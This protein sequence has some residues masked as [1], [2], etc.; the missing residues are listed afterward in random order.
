MAFQ[1]IQRQFLAHL[2]NPEYEPLP[3]GFAEQGAAI[4][5]D[6]LYNKFNDSLELC[7]PVTHNVL[8]EA[9]WQQLL[10]AFIAEHRCKSPYY[11]QIPDEFIRYL[12]TERVS[13]YDPPYLLELAHFEW[14]EMVLA[15]AEAEPVT[16]STLNAVNDW[17]ACRPLFV[18][19]FEVLH[20]FY[21]VQRINAS[22]Q[23]TIPPAQATLILGFR[24]MDD[25]VQFIELQPATARLLEILQS[26]GCTVGEAIEQIA[27]ELEHPET[28]ALLSFGIET[29]THLIQQ[30]AILAARTKLE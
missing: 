24:D 6:L 29:M 3:N 18:P 12:Q 13:E 4:Y 15:I 28:A 16:A 11:R 5:V 14:V 1:T 10:K 2:R 22:Y 17:L 25:V 7:F 19:V 27:A 30:G 8:G 9:A 21:P 26:A 23:P 20:Y